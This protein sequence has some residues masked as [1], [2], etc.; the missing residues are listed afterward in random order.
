MPAVW[1]FRVT[2]PMPKLL[3][4]FAFWVAASLAACASPAPHAPPASAPPT[5]N[6][7]VSAL[8]VSPVATAGVPPA[9]A[10]FPSEPIGPI[11]APF[12]MPPMARPRFPSGVYDVRT[13]GAVADGATKNT[14]AFK[15]AIAAAVAKGGGTVLVPAGRWVTGPIHL[16]SNIHLH[17]ADEIGRAHV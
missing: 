13:F 6:A 9:E 16:A 3:T 15:K 11:N 17:V 10:L 7:P 1:H 14:G 8:T 2:N 5:G 4:P 12:P